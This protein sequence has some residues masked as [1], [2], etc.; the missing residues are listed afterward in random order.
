MARVRQQLA[1]LRARPGIDHLVRA[2]AAFSTLGGNR[3]AAS[4]ALPAFLAFFPLVALAFAGLGF[5]VAGDTGAQRH[6][7]RSVSDYLPGLLCSHD[8]P[9]QRCSG[10]QID[11]AAIA[12]SKASAG[13]LGILGL[14]FAGLGWMGALREALQIVFHRQAVASNPV[15]G[16]VLNLLQLGVLGL[17]LV[18]SVVTGGLAGVAAGTVGGWLGLQGAWAA[19]LLRTVGIAVT[20][21]LN[22]GL[23]MALFRGLGKARVPVRRGAVLGGAGLGLLQQVGALYLARTTGNP[24]YG[25]FAVVVGLLVWLVLVSRL[26]VFAAVWTATVPPEPVIPEPV[27]PAGMARTEGIASGTARTSKGTSTAVLA[28]DPR[29]N[30]IVGEPGGRAD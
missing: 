27:E 7:L 10:Q 13:L 24:V 5:A 26:T 19:A 20:L 11:V 3:L 1:R 29:A 21:A 4:I 6:V 18:A 12:G 14:L 2:V 22:V 30:V 17:G 15:K 8:V 28:A 23:F 25:S 9:G 16:A